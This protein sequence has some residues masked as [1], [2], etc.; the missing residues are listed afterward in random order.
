VPE[1]LP[2]GTGQREWFLHAAFAATVE[3]FRVELDYQFGYHP[4][5]TASYLVRRIGGNQIASGVLGDFVGHRAELGVMVL[6]D[7]PFS[8]E[9]APSFRVDENPPLIQQ[10]KE[11]T[12]TRERLR[13]ELGL[14]ARLYARLGPTQRLELFYEQPLLAAHEEDPFFPIAVPAQGFG[15]AWRVS[16]P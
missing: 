16:A 13:Y 3:P 5:D 11:Y 14:E 7:A 4:G 12:V 10:G 9:L 2:L 1:Q 15:L 8:I 6:P